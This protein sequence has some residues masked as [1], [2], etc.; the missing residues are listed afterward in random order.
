MKRRSKL[1]IKRQ[2]RS[3]IVSTAIVVASLFGVGALKPAEA[4]AQG[5]CVALE[6][7]LKALEA[8]RARLQKSL[9]NA[10]GE[11][12][13][14]LVQQIRELESEIRP[15][16]IAIN[17]KR[18]QRVTMNWNVAGFPREALVFPPVTGGAAKHPLIFAWHGHGG[19]MDNVAD[20]MHF[21]IL[22]P[23]AIVVYPQ[24]LNTVTN[25]AAGGYGW[26]KEKGDD[27]D[28]DL[29]F[30]DAMLTTLR[31]KYSID[32]TRIYTTGFSNGTGFSYLLWV[33]R[34]QILAAMGAVAGVMADSEQ[35]K[36][37]K[38]R[39]L[40]AIF[41]TGPGT[42]SEEVK[43]KTINRARQINS[44]GTGQPCSK[45]VGADS[46]ILYPSTTQTPVREITHSGG[47]EYPDWAPDEI[48]RFF[49][50]HRRP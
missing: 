3:G 28:R 4:L 21:Q 16:Q 42:V 47:H 15:K 9:Q 25:N 35:E 46:C 22:W 30:F 31:Q 48:V 27:S 14:S 7:Q 39:A 45:P 19:K 49:R 24:G 44:T 2:L 23:E 11:E 5:D 32:D 37:A 10:A 26:Q 1:L 41:G 20:S 8:A 12:K 40:I 36:P 34:G 18:C 38:R 43:D 17:E 6:S 50:N 33:E 13:Q 29:K